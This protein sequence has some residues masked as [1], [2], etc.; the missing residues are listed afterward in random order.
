MQAAQ[1]RER[2]GKEKKVVKKPLEKF[3]YDTSH[4]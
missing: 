4:L 3:I 2:K 1:K